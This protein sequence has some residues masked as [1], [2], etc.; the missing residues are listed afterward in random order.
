MFT[1]KKNLVKAFFDEYFYQF[2]LL[3]D[4]GKKVEKKVKSLQ[5]V[6]NSG[7]S[8]LWWK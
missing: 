4:L 8:T 7:L 3:F 5:V 2:L 6:I 1:V